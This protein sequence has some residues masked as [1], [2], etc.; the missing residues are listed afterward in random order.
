MHTLYTMKQNGG[1]KESEINYALGI[2]IIL[3]Q[4][5]FYLESSRLQTQFI[6]MRIIVFIN[7]PTKSITNASAVYKCS[8]SSMD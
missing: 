7:H 8:F 6:I 5:L 3:K 4:R 2:I 1:V